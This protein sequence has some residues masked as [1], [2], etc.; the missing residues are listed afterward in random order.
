MVTTIDNTEYNAARKA[1]LEN[2]E[3]K[4][5]YTALLVKFIYYQ[6]VFSNR[7]KRFNSIEDTGIKRF[8]SGSD[9]KD[10]LNLF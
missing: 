3:T 8:L 7:R 4:S 10:S 5:E 6:H 9:H 1:S 2:S